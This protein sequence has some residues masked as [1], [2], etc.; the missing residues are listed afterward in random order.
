MNVYRSH[1]GFTL[2]EMVVTLAIVGLLAS[3]AAPLTETVIRR[4][5]E[6]ELRTALYQIRDALDAYKRAADSGRIEKSVTSNG[7]PTSLKVLVE[8]ARDLRSP[9]GVKIYFLRRIPRDPF[10]KP[11]RAPEEDWGLRAYDSPAQNPRD[12]EDV[13]D[14]YSKTRGKGLNGIA[15]SEW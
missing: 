10:A 5:K 7:Y 4:G 12:G 1:G 8:G 14:V 13:F 6:Q 15:Y 3:I 9:K 2:I 11:T